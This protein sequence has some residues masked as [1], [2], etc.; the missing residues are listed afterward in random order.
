MTQL[1][2]YVRPLLCLLLLFTTN[3]IYADISD[4]EYD[5][6]SLIFNNHHYD[7]DED[8][9]V[10]QIIINN[11]MTRVLE[12]YFQQLEYH[13]NSDNS[14]STYI[15]KIL[16]IVKNNIFSSMPMY[17]I[18]YAHD[19]NNAYGC[20]VYIYSVSGETEDDI[21]SLLIENSINLSGAVFIGDII[22]AYYHNEEMTVNGTDWAAETWPCDLFY[23]DLDGLWEMAQD[24]TGCYI[25][26]IENVKPEI[27]VGRIN[28]AGMG[29]NEI[30]EMKYYFDR[31]HNYWTGKKPLNKRKALTFTE[32]DWNNSTFWNCVSPL[33]GS[34][35]YDVV[36]ANQFISEDYLNYL[37]NDDYEFIQ[38]ACHSSYNSH[39]FIRPNVDSSYIYS[40]NIYN[41]LKKQIGYNLFCCKACNWMFYSFSPCLGESYLYGINNNSST[42]AL[43][44]STKIGGLLGFTYFYNPLGSGKCIGEAIKQWW[45]NCCGSSHS[46]YETLWHYGLTIMGD[47][48]VNFNFSN[49]CNNE[50]LINKGNETNNS[51]YYAQSQILIQNYSITS[52]IKV[53]MNAPY[54]KI[55]GP[56]RCSSPAKFSTNINDYCVC[57]NRNKKE[58][59]DLPISYNNYVGRKSLVMLYPNPSQDI[60]Y[61]ES[62]NTID[63]VYI[64]NLNGQCM[65]HTTQKEVNVSELPCGVYLLQVKTKVGELLQTKFIKDSR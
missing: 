63:C 35:N 44:G 45:I 58:V 39:K 54:I 5:S 2:K 41:T 46:T 50:L 16:V 51:S 64:Y 25:T 43:I 61:I 62:S 32:F 15:K 21:K 20:E 19:I 14:S 57:S 33:Y 40:A 7:I 36:K 56:F 9:I 29:R 53:E 6:L 24:G 3:R 37:Q 55:I 34:N 23:M 59:R 22:P 26:H 17:I 42:L 65:L 28:T 48:L 47:P 52:S 18:R 13:I 8:S 12:S 1:Q 4:A 30:A 31:N 27:F 60:L 10:R 49:A 38:I 11:K